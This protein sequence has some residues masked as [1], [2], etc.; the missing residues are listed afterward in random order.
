[1]KDYQIYEYK[2]GNYE[3]QVEIIPFPEVKIFVNDDYIMGFNYGYFYIKYQRHLWHINADKSKIYTSE[4]FD[5]LKSNDDKN[6]VEV[7]AYAIVTC[8]KI[9][10]NCAVKWE[11]DKYSKKINAFYKRLPER[12]KALMLIYDF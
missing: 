4:F 11:Q 8:Y 9:F 1:M 5:W 2:E 12:I 7:I 3:I 6:D 10:R